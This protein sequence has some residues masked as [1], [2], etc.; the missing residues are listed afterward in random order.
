MTIEFLRSPLPLLC[1]ALI[2]IACPSRA[3]AGEY[4][5]SG[6]R[7]ELERTAHH[8]AGIVTIVD[9]D[10][11]RV[12]HFDYDGNGISVYV[13]LGG[14]R[15]N[16]GFANGLALGEEL[17]GSVFDDDTLILDLPDGKTL[18]GY[19]AVSVWC[20]VAG[21]SFGWGE[22]AAPCLGDLNGDG[23]VDL[24]DLSTLLVSLGT[25][26]DARPDQGDLDLD[27]DVDLSDLSNLLAVFGAACP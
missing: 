1:A 2:S 15:T 26:M 4:A 7:C 9:A 13:Y 3:A 16:K 23:L 27:G 22:F 10:T 8:V 14:E 12:D 25:A 21:V 6:W 24:A 18:D 11:I 5:R 20:V 19:N 17:V